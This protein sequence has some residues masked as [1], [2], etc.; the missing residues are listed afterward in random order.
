MR[1]S[2]RDDIFVT[3]DKAV[4]STGSTTAARRQCDSIGREVCRGRT[5]RWKRS[6]KKGGQS[7]LPQR[8]APLFAHHTVAH[9]TRVGNVAG[10]TANKIKI[11]VCFV[12]LLIIIGFDGYAV[13]MFKEGV[14]QR[15]VGN[16]AGVTHDTNLK[17]SFLDETEHIAIIG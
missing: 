14:Q 6:E 1:S 13:W 9:K 5:G 11:I 12:F 7:H 2:R 17:W 8:L 3:P 4:V 16:S 10:N 15:A